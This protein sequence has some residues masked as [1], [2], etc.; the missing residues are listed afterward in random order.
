MHTG[1]PFLPGFGGTGASHGV[2]VYSVYSNY[3]HKTPTKTKWQ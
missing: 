3:A 2:T 1:E